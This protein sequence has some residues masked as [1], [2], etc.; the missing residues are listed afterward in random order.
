VWAEADV[1]NFQSLFSTDEFSRRE[2]LYNERGYTGATAD[3]WLKLEDSY[4]IFN[5]YKNKIIR[6]LSKHRKKLISSK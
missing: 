3:F 5:V 1:V 4:S 2:F 6:R